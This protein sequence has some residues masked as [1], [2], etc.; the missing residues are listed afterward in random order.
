MTGA[1]ALN[2]LFEAAAAVIDNVGR[3]TLERVTGTVVVAT[4]PAFVTFRR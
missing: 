2:E 1:E 3:T 4:I